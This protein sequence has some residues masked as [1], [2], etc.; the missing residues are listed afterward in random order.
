MESLQQGATRGD[1]AAGD[2]FRLLTS[3]HVLRGRE[4]NR[5]IGEVERNNLVPKTAVEFCLLPL[6]LQIG[7]PAMSS[8]IGFR[9]FKEDEYRKFIETHSR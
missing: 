4:Q 2:A 6:R 1:P 3:S 9:E 8:A 7:F 5:L